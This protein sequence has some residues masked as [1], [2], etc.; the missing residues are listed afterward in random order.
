[1]SELTMV[2]YDRAHKQAWDSF[3]RQ[4]KNGTFL[5]YRDY[6]EYHADR[7]QDY[8]H[9]FFQDGELLA[10]LP[11]NRTGDHVVSHG[12][13]TYG[14]FI[15]D[16][17]MKASLMLELFGVLLS[18]LRGDGVTQFVYKPVPHI[19][20]RAPAEEDL[21]ALFINGAEL[22]RRDASTALL[23]E[24]RLPPSKGRA[25]ALKRGRELSV[26]ETDDFDTFMAIEEAVLRERHNKKPV[27]TAAELKALARLFPDHIKLFAAYRNDEMLGG[28][29]IYA[30][31]MT[32]H[33]QY[34]SA[35]ED[36][37]RN[38]AQDAVV[39]HLVN[40]VYRDR[41]FFDFGIST[42]NDG[43]YLN[44]GLQQ[45]KESFGARTTVYDFYRLN[46]QT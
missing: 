26:R 8:S 33:A 1:M 12:G 18:G 35:T 34:I 43:R 45:N 28:M 19:Y 16:S 7:F 14:G 23:L 20:H 11:A 25:R 5:F 37:K 6:T 4:S 13:L 24:R 3:V 39:E 29:I 31:E 2:R 9:L 46:L 10:L 38:G 22:F 27:H 21:Y 42:D 15:T 36:G 40:D 32:A 44:L 41:K 17:H 30:D